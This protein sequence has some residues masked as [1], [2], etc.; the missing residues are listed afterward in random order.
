VIAAGMM[1]LAR[2]MPNCEL[3]VW[4]TRRTGGGGGASSATTNLG[5]SSR[6]ELYEDI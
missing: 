6:K 5:S 4:P 3:F 2:S 1:L